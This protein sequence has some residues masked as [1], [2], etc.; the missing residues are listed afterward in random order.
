M[1]GAGAGDVVVLAVVDGVL[2]TRVDP[3]VPDPPHAASADRDAARAMSGKRRIDVTGH[4]SACAGRGGAR[5]HPSSM[6]SSRIPPTVTEKD[7]IDARAASGIR[8]RGVCGVLPVAIRC[9]P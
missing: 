4:G 6:Y 3:L 5:H 8:R 7:E 1:V 9:P 2:G